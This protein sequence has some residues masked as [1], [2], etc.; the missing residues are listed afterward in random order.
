[1]FVQSWTDGK[2]FKVNLHYSEKIFSLCPNKDELVIV[3][4]YNELLELQNLI[5]EKLAEYRA[6]ENKNSSINQRQKE[7][8]N[9]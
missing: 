9:E 2:G 4:S 5:S 7:E 3:T 1:M 6:L 8:K